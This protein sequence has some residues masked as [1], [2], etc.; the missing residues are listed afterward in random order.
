MDMPL[1]GIVEP[2]FLSTVVSHLLSGLK[3]NS[4]VSSCVYIPWCATLG[5]QQLSQSIMFL[6]IS[7]SP[8]VFAFAK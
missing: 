5:P 6:F 1:K 7:Y 3:D 8:Q 2:V 4:F